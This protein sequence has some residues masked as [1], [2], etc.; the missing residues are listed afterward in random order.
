MSQQMAALSSSSPG[1]GASA[2]NEQIPDR[3]VF[4]Q[5]PSNTLQGRRR[6]STVKVGLRRRNTKA[7]KLLHGYVTHSLLDSRLTFDGGPHNVGLGT[8]VPPLTRLSIA[9]CRSAKRERKFH[10]C[11]IGKTTCGRLVVE[12]LKPSGKKGSK[13]GELLWFITCS[14]VPTSLMKS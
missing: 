10:Y 7:V 3:R 4:Q 13:T 2:R 5:R 6:C 12:N 1:Q 14:L 9:H 11:S 8:T